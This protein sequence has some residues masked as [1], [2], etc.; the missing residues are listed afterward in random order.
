M[1]LGQ[2]IGELWEAVQDRIEVSGH[3]STWHVTAGSFDA[4]LAY[5]RARFGE[6]VVLAREDRHRW[7]PRV[8]LTVTTDQAL[9]ASAPS[10]EEIARPPI[11]V[12]TTAD[13]ADEAHAPRGEGD[14]EGRAGRSRSRRQPRRLHEPLPSSLEEIFAH[15]EE[16][17]L[18]RQRVPAHDNRAD[19]Q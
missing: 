7:W 14:H 19:A 17:R 18:A 12:Q 16:L 8:T 1:P 11:P 10:L 6:P 15:Q 4:A 3:D 2:G 9:A 5:A 13:V